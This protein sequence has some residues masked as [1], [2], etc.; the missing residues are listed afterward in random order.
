MWS[1]PYADWRQNRKSDPDPDRH[2]N[3][4]CREYRTLVIF[5]R[6]MHQNPVSFYRM[7]YLPSTEVMPFSLVGVFVLDYL[8]V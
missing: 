4:E 1:D 6:G 3:V 5:S 8:A 2:Q 7:P